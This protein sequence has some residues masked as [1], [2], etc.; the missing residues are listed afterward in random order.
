MA[1]AIALAAGIIAVIQ[2]SDRIIS[3]TK[4]YIEAV[5]DAPRYLHVIRIEV[6]TLKAIFESLKLLQDSEYAS[7][8]ILHKLGEKDGAV[9][10]CERSVSGLEQLLDARYQPTSGGKRRKLQAT[11][12]S[13]AWPLKE[14]KA[15]KLLHEISRYKTTITLS[16]STEQ[17]YVTRSNFSQMLPRLLQIPCRRQRT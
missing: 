15:K 5:Q 9:E 16:L 10:G 1:E 6:S 17:V 2:I 14:S 8:S 4:Q 3:L 11:L 7:S 13:L 12:S